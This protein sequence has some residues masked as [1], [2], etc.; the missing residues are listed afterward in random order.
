MISLK[1]SIYDTLPEGA[2]QYSGC[3]DQAIRF[4]QD[5]QLKDRA[6]WKLFVEQFRSGASDDINTGWR[7]EYWGKVMRGA[8]L[9]YHYTQDSELY[10]IMEESVRDLLSAQDEFGRFSTYSISAEFKMWDVW[11][12]KYVLL[13]FQYFLNVCKREALRTQIIEAMQRHADY[14]MDKIGPEDSGRINITKT[15]AAWDGLNSSSILEPFVRLHVLTG[16]RRYLDFAKYIIDNGAMENFD[17][18]Q[19]A[20][21]DILYPYEYPVTKAYE[22]IS[23]FEGLLWYYRVVKNPRYLDMAEK[24][25]DKVLASDITIIGSAGCTHEL[26]DHSKIHQFDPAF[27]GIMQETCVTVT[28]MKFCYQLLQITGNTK[29]ADAIEISA[30]NALIGT[31]NTKGQRSKG[32]MPEFDSYSPLRLASRGRAMGGFQWISDTL[33]YGCCWAIGAAGTALTALAGASITAAGGIAF[34]LYQ[35]GQILIT[36]PRAQKVSFK[37]DTKYPADAMIAVTVSLSSPEAFEAVFRLPPYGA[38]S[39]LAVNGKIIAQY[40]RGG[41]VTLN[42]EWRDGDVV[43]ITAD[44]SIRLLKDSDI[45]P[46]AAQRTVRYGALLRGPIVLAMDAHAGEFDINDELEFKR[47]IINVQPNKDFDRFPAL[48]AYTVSS[49]E[50]QYIFTDYASCGKIWDEKSKMAA[51]FRMKDQRYK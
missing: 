2:A 9:T 51:W 20:E 37:I 1:P 50:K 43:T 33:A 32:M 15:S 22:M 13:G 29:Y 38:G 10:Q 24:F 31:I 19:A 30:Y 28:W 23:C 46:E 34:H 8:S 18:F 17:L 11:C 42:R 16:E 36:S 4:V 47:G 44:L 5:R 41:S 27:D 25:A 48:M 3:F 35:P 39:T 45:L 21:E 12:R 26:F 6:V 49:G 14:I 40:C 7:G